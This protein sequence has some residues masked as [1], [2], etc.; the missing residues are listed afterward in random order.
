MLCGFKADIVESAQPS[1]IQPNLTWSDLCTRCFITELELRKRART[2]L[3]YGSESQPLTTSSISALRWCISEIMGFVRRAHLMDSSS[4]SW[5]AALAGSLTVYICIV[6]VRYNT[7][8]TVFYTAI[9]GL[10]DKE[11]DRQVDIRNSR[12]VP[13]LWNN[14]G[15]EKAACLDPFH[16]DVIWQWLQTK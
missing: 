3:S 5:K 7:R 6:E 9:K 11:A 12:L 15:Q 14:K 8:L 16:L 13:L 1:I 10:W 2:P 4:W